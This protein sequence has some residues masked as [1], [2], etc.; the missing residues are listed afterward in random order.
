[1]KVALP[2]LEARTTQSPVAVKVTFVPEM[3]QEAEPEATTE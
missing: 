1:L 3:L 2:A